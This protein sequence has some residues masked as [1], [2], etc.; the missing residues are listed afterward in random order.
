MN[1]DF[2]T[3]YSQVNTNISNIAQNASDIDDLDNTK[4]N[5]N[6]SSTQVFSVADATTNVHAVNKQTLKKSITPL[7]DFISGLVISKDSGS[8]NDTILV[9]PGSCYDSTKSVVLGLANST[10]KQN[11]SQGAS[12]TYYIY[13]IG[14]ATGSTTDILISSSS[15]TPT[16]PSG[17]TLF[18]QIGYYTTN[19]SSYIDT[20]FYYGESLNSDKSINKDISAIFPNYNNGIGVNIPYTVTSYGWMYL[21]VDGYDWEH[22]AYV[23]NH[24]VGVSCGYSGGKAV[25]NGVVF[26]VRPGNVVSGYI[27]TAIFYPSKGE[28]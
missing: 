7:L 15:T 9:T 18:R 2:D 20:I 8:P 16:L 6:G 1:A 28:S 23:D 17:Y 27:S 19:S 10:T 13:I 22:P 12:T 5:I 11:D 14:N 3:L 25:R 24:Q 26:P 21:T 4:A